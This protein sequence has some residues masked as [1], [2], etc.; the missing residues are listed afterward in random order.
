[1]ASPTYTETGRR[2]AIS[3][4]LGED[5]LLLRGF[6]GQEGISQLFRFNLDL[7][8]TDDSI[9]LETLVGKNVTVK[10][11][12]ADESE[13]YFNGI[14]ST[15]TQ[16]SRDQNLTSYQAEFV[17]WL[18][19]LTRTA[20]CR[21]F[22]HQTVPEIIQAVFSQHGFRDYDMK[23]AGWFIEREYCVQYRE[24]SFNFVSRLMEE[25]GIY[26]FFKHDDGKHTLVLADTP[27]G[28]PDCP[29]QSSARYHDTGRGQ[30]HEDV[31]NRLNVAQE[32][33][34]SQYTLNDFNFEHPSATMIAQVTSKKDFEVYDY[35][36]EYLR[37]PV[38]QQLARIRLEECET[39][40]IY[41]HGGGDCR[42]FTS[43][44]KFT[45]TD[46]YRQDMNKPYVLT[47]IRHF[48]TLPG[49]F[50]S[51]S[52]ADAADSIYQNTFE[53]IP[54]STPFRPARVTPKPIVQGSQTAFV[55]G[56][57]G[58][59]IYTDKYGRVKVQFHWD[60]LGKHDQNSSCWIRVSQNW[61]G[62]GWGWI[63][64]PRIGHEVVVDF[65]EGDPD[66]PLIT[67]RV[68][69]AEEMPPYELPKHGDMMGFKSNTTKGGGGYNEIVSRDVKGQELIRTHAQKD[70]E[71]VAEDHIEVTAGTYIKLVV[72]KSSLY[73]DKD[74][75]INLEGVHVTVKGSD[76]I[77]L[78]P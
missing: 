14:V 51:S 38:G 22:Q 44:Y 33:R 67:G 9:G 2:F 18:W 1:M 71:T 62:K 77:D 57:K 5:K 41:V 72:G 30:R 78:N 29:H 39:P 55:V 16:N 8:S 6:Q 54:F 76:W 75:I 27:D 31:I 64:I 42:A 32:L 37:Q 34:P 23:L 68:Y 10:V 61:A 12:L 50:R 70:I 58:E 73:M 20:D 25:E 43:G 46:H 15:F 21:I 66:R 4:P 56:E 19:L 48:A 74:G 13:R 59:E 36:G 17:P 7:L 40:Q 53:C 3:T 63:S 24:S 26:Y 35:P 28:H 69:N 52:G 49:D 45:L 47:R 65:L 11:K 60:R